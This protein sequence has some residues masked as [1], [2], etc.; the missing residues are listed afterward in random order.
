MRMERECGMEFE[1]IFE[2]AA[3]VLKGFDKM[4]GF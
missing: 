3:T 4:T 1:G 2:D